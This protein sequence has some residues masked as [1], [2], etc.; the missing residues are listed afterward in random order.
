MSLVYIHEVY[1]FVVAGITKILIPIFDFL[2]FVTR[3]GDKS[4]V[5]PYLVSIELRMT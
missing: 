3:Y 4:V 1:I 2:L 5:F